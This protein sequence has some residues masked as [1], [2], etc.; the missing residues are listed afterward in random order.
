[1]FHTEQASTRIN[2]I[3]IPQT[4]QLHE[5]TLS[6]T[7]HH[8]NNKEIAISQHTMFKTKL[9]ILHYSTETR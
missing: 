8:S 7:V 4:N 1:M 6:T 5:L 3:S 2:Y 9:T